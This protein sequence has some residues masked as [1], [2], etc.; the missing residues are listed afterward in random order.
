MDVYLL[1][2]KHS[3]WEIICQNW[4]RSNESD[5]SY[6]K[7]VKSPRNKSHFIYMATNRLDNK[8]KTSLKSTVEIT[9]S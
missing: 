3:G 6:S 5:L 4:N 7:A 9:E 1:N 2:Y 8:H